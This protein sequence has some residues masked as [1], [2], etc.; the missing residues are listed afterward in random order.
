MEVKKL[1]IFSFV[2]LLNFG[3]QK[4]IIDALL[5]DRSL[6]KNMF[7]K[8]SLTCRQNINPSVFSEYCSNCV[9]RGTNPDLK[10]LFH[11]LTLFQPGFFVPCS[12]GGGGG[13]IAPLFAK[14]EKLEHSNLA[15]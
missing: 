10:M 8:E 9:F 15:Q 5:E 2:L 6:R 12:M 3:N 13:L 11:I 7:K 14:L 4:S 1:I